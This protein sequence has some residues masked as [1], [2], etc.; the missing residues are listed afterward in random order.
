MATSDGTSLPLLEVASL[1]PWAGCSSTAS[2][3]VA[4]LVATLCYSL[5]VYL[6]TSLCAPLAGDEKS[7]GGDGAILV[8]EGTTASLFQPAPAQTEL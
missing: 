1:L 2:L 4:Y 3:L 7:I 8:T 5:V 6:K